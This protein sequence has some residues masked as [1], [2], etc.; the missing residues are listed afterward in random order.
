MMTRLRL[1]AI[2]AAAA[3]ALIVPASA[4][5]SH[6][7]TGQPHVMTLASAIQAFVKV[8]HRDPHICL[9]SA[10]GYCHHSHGAGNQLTIQFCGI[11]PC[12]PNYDESFP[13]GGDIQLQIDSSNECVRGQT[14]A[15]TVITDNGNCDPGDNG[16]LWAIC[17]SSCGNNYTLK[18]ESTGQ[19]MDVAAAS[20]EAA[21]YL[22]TCQSGDGNWC[23]WGFY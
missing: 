17:Q 4:S 22:G 7:Q 6:A 11:N 13:G 21:M 14:I 1:A 8:H 9:H 16:E 2:A 5:A 15:G 20:S 18:V 3:L 23:H 19:Y 10:T 12:G